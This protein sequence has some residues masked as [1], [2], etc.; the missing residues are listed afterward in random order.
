MLSEVIHSRHSYPANALGRTAGTP[1]VSSLRSSRTRSKSSQESTSAVD[2]RPT[3]LTHLR[4]TLLCG[5][6]YTFTISCGRFVVSTK[7]IKK[8]LIFF[9]VL[10]FT[11]VF[12]IPPKTPTSFYIIYAEPPCVHI[13]CTWLISIL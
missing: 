7:K 4:H 5:L 9:S 6:D 1:E 8:F 2:R 13:L 11:F 10:S 3:C 12:R